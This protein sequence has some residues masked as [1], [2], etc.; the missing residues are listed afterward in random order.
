[1]KNVSDGFLEFV[2]DQ[3]REVPDVTARAMFG[4]IGLYAAAAFF[5]IIWGDVVYLKVDESTRPD[6]ERAGMSAFK[7]YN[8]R[9]TTFAYYSVP[10]GVLESPPEFS[11]WARK[12]IDA[13]RRAPRR[14]RRSTKG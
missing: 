11:R 13:A 4:G 3:L 2:L 14:R 7:P 12:A 9:P 1:M 8:H 5:A 6:Y 10:P